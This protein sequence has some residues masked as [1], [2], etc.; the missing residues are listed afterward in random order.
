MI[1]TGLSESKYFLELGQRMACLYPSLVF[2][3]LCP[4]P[5]FLLIPLYLSPSPPALF[6]PPSLWLHFSLSLPLHLSISP[7][8]SLLAELVNSD[9]S[10]LWRDFKER[11]GRKWENDGLTSSPVPIGSRGN[12][13]PPLPWQLHLSWRWR[14][15]GRAPTGI[16]NAPSSR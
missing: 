8:C 15:E 4:L 2:I 1:G 13:S 11:L 5:L 14:G 9:C 16:S 6:T 10:T 12:Q 7:P 3:S